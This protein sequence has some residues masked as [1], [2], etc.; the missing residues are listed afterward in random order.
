MKKLI[1][2]IAMLMATSAWAEVKT[3]NCEVEVKDEDLIVLGKY[4]ALINFDYD[5]AQAEVKISNSEDDTIIEEIY[6]LQVA[7]SKLT[8]TNLKENAHLVINRQD[9]GITFRGS[10]DRRMVPT[11]GKCKIVRSKKNLI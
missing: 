1:L 3:L 9:L 6:V 10:L 7:P 4:F 5:H 8:F 2:L 11:V